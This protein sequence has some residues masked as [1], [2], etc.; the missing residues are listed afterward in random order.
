MLNAAVGL[1]LSMSSK[2]SPR[3]LSTLLSRDGTHGCSPG[4]LIQQGHFAEDLAG[5]PHGDDNILYIRFL[6]DLEFP[7]DHDVRRVSGSAF[8]DQVGPR[9]HSHGIRL[10]GQGVEVGL[11]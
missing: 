7:I 2:A 5:F 10:R 8:L 11:G 3:I 4:R 6:D 9:L 1:R